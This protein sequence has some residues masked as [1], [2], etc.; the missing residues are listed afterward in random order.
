MNVLYES[1]RYDSLAAERVSWLVG[2]ELT[3]RSVR[4]TVLI[5]LVADRSANQTHERRAYTD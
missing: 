4:A 3:V 1:I 5:V 2:N